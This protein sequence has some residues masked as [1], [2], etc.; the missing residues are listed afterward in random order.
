MAA[1]GI[2]TPKGRFVDSR[3]AAHNM[4]CLEAIEALSEYLAGELP[5]PRRDRLDEHL[6]ECVACRQYLR[7]FEQTIQ[8]GKAVW[9]APK[10]GILS[11]LPEELIQAIL[12]S[13][14]A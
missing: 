11:E 3:R 5:P 13:R 1:R 9:Q 7:S 8:L 12:A 14:R 10:N 6:T 2:Q 4:T